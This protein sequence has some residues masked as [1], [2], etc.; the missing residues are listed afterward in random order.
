M[1]PS[2]INTTNID[3]SHYIQREILIHLRQQGSSTYQKL[4]PAGLEGNAYNYHLRLLKQSGLI[5]SEKK[6][7]TLTNIGY[8]VSDAYSYASRRL[9][10]RPHMYTVLFVVSSEEV[11]VYQHHA[12]PLKGMIGLP[13]GK[14]H[15]NEGFTTSV[16]KEAGRRELSDDYNVTTLCPINIRYQQ[17]SQPVV[18]RPGILWHLDYKGPL[19]ERQTDNGRSFWIKQTDSEAAQIL[20]EVRE[21]LRR[22]SESSTQ[23]IDMDYPL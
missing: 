22:L 3:L 8:L 19:S 20:P 13:S 6:E 9:M 5:A 7:Y 2:D 23:P 18:H 17:N 14:V 1:T 4:K 11:L 21:G 15:Y 16:A 10:L 12:G